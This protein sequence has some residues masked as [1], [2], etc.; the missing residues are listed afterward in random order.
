MEHL[1]VPKEIIEFD[2]KYSFQN[3]LLHFVPTE[4]INY[5]LS[6][7]EVEDLAMVRLTC[8]FF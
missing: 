8:K 1:I 7:L 6:Y 3:S 2:E 5:I 4:I